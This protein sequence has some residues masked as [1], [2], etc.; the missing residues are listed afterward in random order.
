M[1]GENGARISRQKKAPMLDREDEDICEVQQGI[2]M[3]GLRGEVID[4]LTN[5]DMD[6]LK[7]RQLLGIRQKTR[8]ALQKTH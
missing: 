7:E 1:V 3:L 2:G 5:A 4:W 8:K 6:I